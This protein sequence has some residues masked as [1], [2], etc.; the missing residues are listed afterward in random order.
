MLTTTS[1]CMYV[2]VPTSRYILSLL[3]TDDINS[4]NKTLSV[5]IVLYVCMY[6]CIQEA[7]LVGGESFQA[8]QSEFALTAGVVDRSQSTSNPPVTQEGWSCEACTFLNN[9]SASTCEI[10]AAV[11]PTMKLKTRS[12]ASKATS[13]GGGSVNSSSNRSTSPIVS[14]DGRALVAP[15]S[16]IDKVRSPATADT[17]TT[18]ISSGRRDRRRQ[19]ASDSSIF[20]PPPLPP[21]ASGRSNRKRK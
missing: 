19:Q 13:S 15:S 9:S 3:N 12:K 1:V 17:T 10:C 4:T 14:V 7:M 2:C 11:N 20:S 16:T 21:S 8:T 5:C 6:V 18:T